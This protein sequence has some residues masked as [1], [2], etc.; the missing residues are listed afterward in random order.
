MPIVKF[1]EDGIE[2]V[3]ELL[4]KFNGVGSSGENDGRLQDWEIELMDYMKRLIHK[5]KLFDYNRPHFIFD[6]TF[7]EMT[8]FFTDLELKVL[9][10]LESATDD[11]QSP[12]G[13]MSVPSELA[14]LTANSQMLFEVCRVCCHHKPNQMVDIFATDG[15]PDGLSYA[16]KIGMCVD[17]P[18]IDDQDTLPKS[19]CRDCVGSLGTCYEFQ[20]LCRDSDF[21]LRRDKTLRDLIMEQVLDK[22]MGSGGGTSPMM[23]DTLLLGVDSPEMTAV[24]E[25]T[26]TTDVG[27]ESPD[28]DVHGRSIKTTTNRDDEIC[29]IR[30]F[31]CE[32]CGARFFDIYNFKTHF[33]IHKIVKKYECT[34]CGKKFR[35]N[36]MLKIHTRYVHLC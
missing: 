30:K 14:S 19:I 2:T 4:D 5:K 25:E 8:D 6:N 15:S 33:R 22:T 24:E 18:P 16:T 3:K 35:T 34:E 13:F 36:V 7:D 29:D 1:L 21:E 23:N 32:I 20:K 17:L 27:S 10:L 11:W 9:T 31:Q 26:T 28:S 12:S